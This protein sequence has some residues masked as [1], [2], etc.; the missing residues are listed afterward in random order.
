MEN[1]WLEIAYIN[2]D[3]AIMHGQVQEKKLDGNFYIE[4]QVEQILTEEQRRLVEDLNFK[5]QCERKAVLKGF[6]V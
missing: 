3:K 1:E 2:F 6:V 4:R 5:H